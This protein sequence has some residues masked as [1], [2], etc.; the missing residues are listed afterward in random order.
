[1]VAYGIEHQIWAVTQHVLMGSSSLRVG[2]ELATFAVADR[3]HVVL[4]DEDRDLPG[5]DGVVLVDVPECPEDHEDE[6]AGV[7]LELGALVRRECILDGERVQVEGVGYLLELGCG[8]FVQAHPDEAVRLAGSHLPR[9][10]D[11]VRAVRQVDPSA[12]AVDAQSMIT[13]PL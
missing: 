1:M 3:D 12:A 6:V 8:G 10:D 11:V 7:P 5:L 9:R 2:A 13:G 4:S